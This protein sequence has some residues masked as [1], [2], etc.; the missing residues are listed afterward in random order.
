MDEG[1]A[2]EDAAV[3]FAEPDPL[4]ALPELT[5][6]PRA[7]TAGGL[8]R[9]L[10]ELTRTGR[11]ELA[12]WLV[13]RAASFAIVIFT[14]ERLVNGDAK[15]YGQSL[16][17][18]FHG[19]SL[20]HTLPEYPLPVIGLL[21]VPFLLSGMYVHV[22]VFVFGA[23]MLLVD[24]AFALA[25]WRMGGRARVAALRFWIWFVPALGPMVYFRYDLAPA[26]LA[27]MA[28]LLVVRRGSWS[29]TVA[30]LAAALKV[31]PAMLV[32][33]LALHRN[34]RSMLRA[35]LLTGS[36]AAI[37]SMIIGGVHRSTSPVTWQ[38]SR[39]LQIESIAATPLVFAHSVVHGGGAWRVSLTRFKA[40][41]IVGPGVHAAQYVATALTVGA[42]AALVTLWLF[43]RRL[44]PLSPRLLGWLALTAVLFIVI[45]NKVLSPQ[46]L[47]W[48]GAAAAVL[49][50]L[51]PGR[52][53]VQVATMLV[54]VALLTQTVYPIGY[55]DLV[56]NSGHL[57]ALTAW[58][59]LVR[60][61]LLCGIAAFTA[62]TTMRVMREPA[63]A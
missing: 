45:A 40:Y 50:V 18:L 31:W 48:A 62:I 53:S 6:P 38:G 60:N 42:I 23:T 13:T 57:T 26:A 43:A 21:V 54:V 41:E 56:H 16:H 25:L 9:R 1:A 5:E 61:V 59:L 11:F 37:A 28:V 33:M 15:Y 34:G 49:L 32:P 30:A 51:D 29:G 47:L 14:T 55:H 12:A 58:M 7:A 20:A 63:T 19:G 2:V 24:A 44:R 22:Y 46:Y 3:G 8:A 39:G 27:A 10:R 35:F 36:V 4:A 17:H 52:R